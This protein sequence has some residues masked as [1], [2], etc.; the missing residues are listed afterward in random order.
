[1]QKP[2]KIY[3]IQNFLNNKIY[4]GQTSST[5]SH[6][7]SQ[8]KYKKYK[9]CIYLFNAFE[10]YGRENF[11]I[12]LLM[13]N[14]DLEEANFWECYYIEIFDSKNRNRGYNLMD[15]GSSGK[16]SPETIE[17]I[18]KIQGSPEMRQRKREKLLG[19]K[20][21]NFGKKGKDAHAYGRKH[22][23]DELEKMR[24]RKVSEDEKRN[25]SESHIGEKNQMAKHTNEEIISLKEEAKTWK[26]SKKALA[27]KYNMSYGV[28]KNILNGS[29]WK[30]VNP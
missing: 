10:K 22:T 19:E 30:T 9:K 25:L 21:P 5:L 20:S 29:R 6:R 15:G 23:E 7:F 24:G 18:K 26:L 8:H 11:R 27:K 2:Y 14:L 1:M 3:I 4:I 13:G 17:K 12:E 28:M 16:H